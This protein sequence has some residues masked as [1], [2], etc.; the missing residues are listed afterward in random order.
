MKIVFVDLKYRGRKDKTA[1]LDKENLEAELLPFQLQNGNI[2][3]FQIMP[4]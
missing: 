2:Y 3:F 1:L 4:W